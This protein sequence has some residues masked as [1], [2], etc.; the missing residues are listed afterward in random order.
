MERVEA[1]VAVVGEAEGEEVDDDDLGMSGGRRRY[2]RG[3]DAD[4]EEE[5]KVVQEA[6]WIVSNVTSL[7]SV[8]RVG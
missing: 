5:W 8:E 7:G 4:E 3:E 1:L 6:V 2:R